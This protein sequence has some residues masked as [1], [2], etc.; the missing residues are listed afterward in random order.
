MTRDH[1]RLHNRLQ[2]L[3]EEAHIKLSSL[4]S[5]REFARCQCP[6]HAEGTELTEKPARRIWPP[7]PISSCE[8]HWNNC[9]TRC[10]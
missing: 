5:G 10:Q 2:F 7:W 8:P 3:L 9:V 1:V 4:Q 6:A